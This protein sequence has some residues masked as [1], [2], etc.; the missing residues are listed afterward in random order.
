[1]KDE[2]E[3]LDLMLKDQEDQASVYRPGSEWAGKILGM[4]DE[5]RTQGLANFRSGNA[6]GRS[7]S[8]AIVF[9]LTTQWDLRSW[10]RRA[11]KRFIE[12]P[13]VNQFLIQPFIRRLEEYFNS[14]QRYRNLYYRAEYGELFGRLFSLYD[15][16]DTFVGNPR[17]VLEINGVQ[18]QSL[19]Y[20]QRLLLIHNYSQKVDFK[21]VRTVF[22]IGG[23]VGTNAHLLLHLFPNIR[24]YIYLDIPPVIYVAT[25]YL[26]HF[27]PGEVDDYRRT[28]SLDIIKVSE[29]DKRQIITIC[30]W[31][32]PTVE[33][34]VDLVW[35]S[36]S[37]EEM[38]ISTVHQ[39]SEHVKRL[40][41]GKPEASLCFYI[42]G[43]GNSQVGPITEPFSNRFRFEE[44]VPRDVLE[45]SSYH[46][47]LGRP[48]A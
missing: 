1:M 30:P 4:S 29:D 6:I 17:Q 22:E 23:G 16:P 32:L 38:D 27:F 11:L 14:M 18:Q 5:I 25:Q 41:V 24:K 37:F 36:A 26:K 9:D 39:Y 13:H 3:I 8:D 12:I 33:A 15:L 19:T 46:Y 40:T 31:Q 2:I 43:Q 28:R 44:L 42:G 20:V 7:Y 45:A 10:K 35:N 21:K 47:I 48:T 34:E